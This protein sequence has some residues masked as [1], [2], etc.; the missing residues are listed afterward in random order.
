MNTYSRSLENLIAAAYLS[1]AAEGLR[2]SK[3]LTTSDVQKNLDDIKTL[4]HKFVERA[5]EEGYRQPVHHIEQAK[6]M[7]YDLLLQHTKYPA[8]NIHT[9]SHNITHPATIISPVTNISSSTPSHNIIHP[10]TNISSTPSN[11]HISPN[12]TPSSSSTSPLPLV[13]HLGGKRKSRRSTK[14][15]H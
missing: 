4:R 11:L 9:P 12:S 10:A 5:E 1:G 14:R 7:A 8:K 15:R 3:E 13:V 6:K 2:K